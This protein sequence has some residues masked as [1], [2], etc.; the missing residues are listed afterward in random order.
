[1]VH[2][3]FKPA[4]DSLFIGR[5]LAE[6]KAREKAQEEAQAMQEAACDRCRGSGLVTLFGAGEYGGDA[7]DQPCPDC[8]R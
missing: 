2:P 8:D 4:L 6:E 1:M 7:D 3:I 5:Q